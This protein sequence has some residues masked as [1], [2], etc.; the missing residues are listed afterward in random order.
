M[1]LIST[2][3][4]KKSSVTIDANGEETDALLVHAGGTYYLSISGDY[5]GTI[6]LQRSLDGVTF[7]SVEDYAA[8]GASST[9]KDVIASVSAF[10]KAKAT[11]WS[12]GS[13]DVDLATS[14]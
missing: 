12:S 6:T 8:T 1:A 14:S 3:G 5:T 7:R 4:R 11:A 2:P 9:Q 10:Y 13:A